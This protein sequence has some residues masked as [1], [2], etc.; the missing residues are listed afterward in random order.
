[1][2]AFNRLAEADARVQAVERERDEALS[3]AAAAKMAK[4]EAEREA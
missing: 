2:E 1:M 4:E 3:Q